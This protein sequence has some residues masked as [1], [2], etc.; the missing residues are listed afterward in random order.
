MICIGESML[1]VI[2]K[3]L[4]QQI[5]HYVTAFVSFAFVYWL[6]IAYIMDKHLTNK[7][8]RR[9][10][11]YNGSKWFN[12]MLYIFLHLPIT[13]ALICTAVGLKLMFIALKG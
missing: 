5:T 6:R 7:N 8:T 12:S 4:K 3:D 1:A 10:A 13:F 11:I 9:H 2:L